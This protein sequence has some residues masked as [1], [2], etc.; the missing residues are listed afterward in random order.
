VPEGRGG[1]KKQS[2]TV[3]TR[4]ARRPQGQGAVVGRHHLGIP[5]N[6]NAPNVRGVEG[7]IGCGFSI[8]PQIQLVAI[9]VGKG[10]RLNGIIAIKGNMYAFC[11]Q[12][13]HSGMHI[14]YLK[15]HLHIVAKGYLFIALRMLGYE[16]FN[17]SLV[18]SVAHLLGKARLV[19]IKVNGF[20]HIGNIHHG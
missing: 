12:R 16:G 20:V 1:F 19:G 4:V 10:C 14:I 6:S 17:F 5:S 13:F 7:F 9:G 15:S 3:R 2:P 8:T 18:V 11:F